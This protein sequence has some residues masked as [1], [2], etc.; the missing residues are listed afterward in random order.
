MTSRLGGIFKQL[1]SFEI[2]YRSLNFDEHLSQLLYL[3]SNVK[4]VS[5]RFKLNVK[6]TYI[7]T[8]LFPTHY[9]M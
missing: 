8:I 3:N 6:W 1:K 9:Q 4:I 5:H 2:Q 7:T